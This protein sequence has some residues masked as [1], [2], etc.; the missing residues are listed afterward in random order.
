MKWSSYITN[1][2]FLQ[3]RLI[4]VALHIRSNM[5][6]TVSICYQLELGP[7]LPPHIAE[8]ARQQGENSD[9]VCQSLQQLKD[10]IYGNLKK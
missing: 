8:I 2:E 5:P 3:K 9:S 1:C 6:G 4:I 7:D 10:M